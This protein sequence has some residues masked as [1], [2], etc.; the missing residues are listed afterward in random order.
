MDSLA[1]GDDLQLPR[2]SLIPGEGFFIADEQT[3]EER[4]AAV[5]ETLADHTVA[6]IVDSDADGLG[7]AAILAES[8]GDLALFPSN[9]HDFSNTLEFVAE[10]ATDDVTLYLC[11]LAPDRY[12]RIQDALTT[13]NDTGVTVIWYDHHQWDETL[14]ESVRVHTDEIVIGDS[15]AECTADVVVRSL[16]EPIPDHLTELAVVTRD[17]DLWIKEDP[18]SD[19]IADYAY[20]E[21]PE[22]YVAVVKENGADLPDT[23]QDFLAEQRAE[24]DA[25]ID[26]AVNR[27]EFVEIGAWTIGV[28]YG[29]CSQNEV[30][31][32]LRTEGAD[33]AVIIKPAGSASIRGSDSFERCHEVAEFVNGGG[34]PK[35]AGCKPAIYQDMLDYAH[36]WVTQGAVARREI[37]RGFEQIAEK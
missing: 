26:L 21:E 32:R 27:A 20:W 23:V 6:A 18:R 7:S 30:A 29:R 12:D 15:S 2:K 31:D 10:H 35:A 36:H 5:K 19:D 8:K 24:K 1:F 33:A 3:D 14:L 22:E 13:L 25:L 11:D 37:L 9:P 17:H 28:T 16:G 34:H 4:S